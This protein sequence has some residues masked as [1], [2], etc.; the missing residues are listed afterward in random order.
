VL[1]NVER[2]LDLGFVSIPPLF[3]A[4]QVVLG[5]LF[6]LMMIFRPRGLLGDGEITLSA[7][8]RLTPISATPEE[9]I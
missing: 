3:G 8:K 2:G 4:S 7:L 6:I 5:V 1:R 9:Q